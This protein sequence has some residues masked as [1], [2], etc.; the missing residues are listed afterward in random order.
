MSL[1]LQTID[2]R[3]APSRSCLVGNVRAY[4]PPY[5]A[6][7]IRL[8]AHRSGQSTFVLKDIPK[9]I[10]S[11]FNED[12]RPRLSKSPFLRLPHDT[13]PDHRVFVYKYMDDDFLSLV[14]KQI[15]MQTR[16]QILKAS[17]KGIAELHSHDIVHLGK[18]K[19]S[20]VL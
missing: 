14:R 3:E 12:V 10:F 19:H 9:A 15:P 2:T 17:L 6:K 1:S 5:I 8:T 16:K 7:L 20:S 11:S 18:K 4:Q 13:I